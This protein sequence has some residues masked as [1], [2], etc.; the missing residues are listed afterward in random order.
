MN[1]SNYSEY[2]DRIAR[3][4]EPK[5]NIT[6]LTKSNIDSY[7]KC[8]SFERF[9]ENIINYY[10]ELL[11]ENQVDFAQYYE[12]FLNERGK[13]PTIIKAILNFEIH[14]KSILAYHV[15][16][17]YKLTDAQ[18]LSSFL[19]SLKLNLIGLH[20]SNAR[21]KHMADHMDSL[22]KDV[23]KYADKYCFFDR[24]SLG[25]VLTVFSCLDRKM[26][27]NIF[28]DMKK[29]QLNFDVDKI[30][31][32]KEKI[33]TLVNIRNCVMHDNSI[34]ILFRFYNPKTHELRKVSDRKKYQ[35]VLKWI[36]KNH[37]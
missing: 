27:Q 17:K 37:G 33:F 36:E 1:N 32:F 5:L 7:V 13:Y 25:S 20:Y 12:C 22:K 31:D 9:D 23:T 10:S 26:Q 28:D 11:Y 16:M 24:M 21:I 35:K 6:S 4:L 29:Y 19:E 18:E 15:F 14:F 34:E 30:S 8:D 2:Y 3:I